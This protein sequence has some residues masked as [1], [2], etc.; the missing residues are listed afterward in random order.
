MTGTT[1]GVSNNP[2]CRFMA[3]VGKPT[4]A[5]RGPEER[6]GGWTAFLHDYLAPLYRQTHGQQQHRAAEETT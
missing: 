3:E 4:W 6:R 1:A 5:A 2:W